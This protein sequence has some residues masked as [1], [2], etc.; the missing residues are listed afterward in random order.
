MAIAYT[1]ALKLYLSLMNNTLGSDEQQALLVSFNNANSPFAVVFI[2]LTSGASYSLVTLPPT[3]VSIL[4]VPTV[5]NAGTITLAA[6]NGDTG[7]VFA[8]TQPI[9][10]FSNSNFYVKTSANTSY[11]AYFL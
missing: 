3:C 4:M 9:L 6:N 2:P 10:W 1:A 7:A 11:Q 8:A 5:G